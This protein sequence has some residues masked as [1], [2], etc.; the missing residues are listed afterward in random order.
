MK[1]YAKYLKPHIIYFVLGP[2]LMLTEVLGEVLL[3]KTV[4]E[5]INMCYATDATTYDVLMKGRNMLLVILLMIIGGV[6]GNYCG[7]NAAVRF[8]TDLRADI[9]KKV[10]TFSFKNIDAYSTGSLITRM[11]NDI[12]QIQNVVRMLLIS[13][14]RSPGMLIGAFVMALQLN[15]KLSAV[16]AVVTP[17]LAIAIGLIIC[18]AAPRFESMQKKIDRLNSNIQE[19][20]TNVRVIKSFVRRD[21]EI[22]KFDNVNKDLKDTS[23][24]AFKIVILN[25]PVMTLAMNITTIMVVWFGGNMVL[26]NKM[27]V[28]DL[29]AFVTY[30]T[31][32][33]MSLRMLAM[34][35]L[36][37]S[38][39]VA[40]VRRINEVL[41][42]NVDLTD[43]NARYKDKKVEKGAIEF[44]NVSFG[45]GSTEEEII[46]KD[47]NFKVNPG[48]F[49]G[50]IGAT[51]CG[52]T[53]L[54]QLIPRL[55]DTT[56]GQVLIDGIDVKDYSIRH[57]RDGVGMVLQK[58][59]LFSGTIME[60]LLWGDE[61]ASFDEVVKA[62]DN[63]QADSFVKS[64]VDG[65]ETEL[66]QGGVNVSGGQKQRLCIARALLKKPK[67]LILD[68]STSAVDTATES[69][70]RNAFYNELEDTTK[71]VIAQ[72]ITSVEGADRI[73]V[74]DNGM[75]V[76]FGTHKE[77]MLNNETYK[78]IYYS[79]KE[80]EGE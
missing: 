9:F 17:L 16:I 42:T 50:I 63:A 60:N 5:I 23:V 79:Q 24:G 51:G 40:C 65:Y 57:L 53:S 7:T 22:D 78:E 66:G 32:I 6:G 28:G 45:Y 34:I 29:S 11:T 3:P 67:I 35:L 43:D 80:K 69:K 10:Q 26:E 73:I 18:N 19:S 76:G 20:L 13:L 54:V 74:L 25:S 37:G 8:A 1:R 14:L 61:N 55:Y 38:R 64:F 39:A 72:R 33:L 58:N 2:I 30:I 68:D 21:F 62:S 44:R 75:V 46:L 47:I 15:V 36:Q 41:D 56:K 71:I 77:L 52:K 48:E 59:V 49:V 27:E 12:T 4:A 70:I 31:Q